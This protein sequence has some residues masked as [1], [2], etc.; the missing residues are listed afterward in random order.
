MDAL[1]PTLLCIYR[2]EQQGGA[3][4]LSPLNKQNRA[5]LKPQSV[6]QS[7]PTKIGPLDLNRQRGPHSVSPVA[8]V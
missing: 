3:A 7:N 2:Y 6:S 5:G 4:S 1:G 8:V